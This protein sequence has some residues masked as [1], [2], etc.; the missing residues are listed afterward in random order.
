MHEK[1]S[2]ESADRRKVKFV[3]LLGGAA[4][5]I[6]VINV[7]EW[8]APA[9]DAPL[10]KDHLWVLAREILEK[11]EGTGDRGQGDGQVAVMRI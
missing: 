3:R 2:G 8:R 6:D 11:T 4:L 9:A 10:F 5:N 1:W 7:V